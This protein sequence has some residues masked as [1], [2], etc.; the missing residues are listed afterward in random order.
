MKKQHNTTFLLVILLLLSASIGILHGRKKGVDPAF[1]ADD[2]RVI[3][4]QQDAI[5][6]VQPYLMS[7]NIDAAAA[8][9][10]EFADPLLV[11]TIDTIL[12]NK[13]I[14]LSDEQKVQLLVA[15]LA[16]EKDT[17]KQ[18]IIIDRLRRYFSEYPLFVAMVP[19][20]TKI[21]PRIIASLNN[22][23][24]KEQLASWVKQSL[25]AILKRDDVDLLTA[26][27]DAGMPFDAIQASPL[28]YQLVSEN[29]KSAFIPFFIQQLKAD[30][31][32]SPDGS[33]TPLIKAVEQNNLPMVK[34]LLAQGADPDQ[35]LDSKMGSAR[36]VA[37]ER[38]YTPIELI[39]RKRR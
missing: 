12:H 26:L 20:Y 35:I 27:Y 38:S 11:K 5:D 1:V 10:V 25:Q 37:F 24:G 3:L 14:V 29:K 30:I 34:A 36:Q 8:A 32:Y 21:I 9:A 28:L 2:A 23:Q 33:R 13:T 16:H 6:Y 15:I 17:K 7:G 4:D 19:H 18:K 22:K 31:N 39:L